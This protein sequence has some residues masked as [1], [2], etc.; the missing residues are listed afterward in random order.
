MKGTASP[1]TLRGCIS[2]S[3]SASFEA[4]AKA[5]SLAAEINRAHPDAKVELIDGGRGDFI[6]KADGVELWNKNASGRGF[7]EHSQILERLT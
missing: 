3:N 5:V 6:V 1:A 2:L 4:T 7:P